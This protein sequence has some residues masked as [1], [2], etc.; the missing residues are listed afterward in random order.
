M[1]TNDLTTDRVR[2]LAGVF[3]DGHTSETIDEHLDTVAHLTGLD[4]VCI[5][6]NHD[7]QGTYGH[8][9]I[10]ARADGQLRELP[11]GLLDYLTNPDAPIPPALHAPASTAVASGDVDRWPA[12]ADLAQV[13]R[14]NYVVDDE[15]GGGP[16][17]QEIPASMTGV[18]KMDDVSRVTESMAAVRV[19]IPV[20]LLRRFQR[21]SS[22]I[23]RYGSNDAEHDVLAE[24]M[25]L[26]RPI[27]EDPGYSNWTFTLYLSRALTD[28]ELDRVDRIEGTCDSLIQDM[29]PAPYE[30]AGETYTHLLSTDVEAVPLGVVQQLVRDV[31][32]DVLAAQD[33]TV[34]IWAINES[35]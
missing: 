24:V 35:D 27:V 10:L 2:A 26:V 20:E 11:D 8:S 17:A 16:R 29:L 34:L 32:R 14:R 25:D 23:D 1:N 6:E 5:W 30:H 28:T 3:V 9:E 7:D 21:A 31:R 22:D 13:S 18:E 33:V 4:V 12:A 15:T 19:E